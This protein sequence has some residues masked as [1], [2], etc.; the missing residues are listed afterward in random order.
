MILMT[1]GDKPMLDREEQAQFEIDFITFL[2]MQEGMTYE[3]ARA[4]AV[5]EWREFQDHSC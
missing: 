1:G 2:H 4:W 3:K 5:K